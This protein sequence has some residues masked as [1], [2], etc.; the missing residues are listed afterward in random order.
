MALQV[1]SFTFG[2]K[3]E[4]ANSFRSKRLRHLF[5]TACGNAHIDPG[6]T[7]AFM[8]RT[9]DVSASYLEK[10]NGLFL[11]EY[12]RVEPYA[13]VLG[14]EKS[15]ITEMAEEMQDLT[16]KVEELEQELAQG[17]DKMIELYDNVESLRARN[18][19]LEVRIKDAEKRRDTDMRELKTLILKMTGVKVEHLREAYEK[20]QRDIDRE[21]QEDEEK[22]H[23][24]ILKEIR[25]GNG[26]EKP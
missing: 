10:S 25:R 2:V 16:G 21:L 6:F 11:K 14:V 3:K 8:G 17:K 12:V 24:E 26:V 4:E 18:K 1:T 15:G 5:R 9:S 19:E 13:T 23:E 22:E 7:M 20:T